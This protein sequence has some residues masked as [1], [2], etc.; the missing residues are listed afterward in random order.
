M[1]GSLLNKK[2]ENERDQLD[3]VPFL[4]VYHELMLDHCGPPSSFESPSR[5]S[6]ISA[7]IRA[8]PYACEGANIK[9]EE[10]MQFVLRVHSRAH[11]A[12]LDSLAGSLASERSKW[13]CSTCSFV[14]EPT[15][16]LCDMCK[17]RQPKNKWLYFEQ[18]DGDTTY[19]NSATRTA[20]LKAVKCACKLALMLVQ[21]ET[22][23]GFAVV[24]PPGHHAG[25]ERVEGFCVLNS[26]AI[27]AE[28]ALAAG[29]KRIFIFDWDV[30]HGNGIQ[31]HFY[32]RADVFYASIHAEGIYP[33][34][35]NEEDV[36]DGEGVG[37]TLNVPLS[38]GTDT[39]QYVHAFTRAILPAMEGYAPDL[40]IIAAGF[41]ALSSDPMH[42]FDVNQSAY[43]TMLS[44][45]SAA[46]PTTPVGLI[47]EGGYDSRSIASAIDHCAQVLFDMKS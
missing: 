24:R 46:L 21:G 42:I 4:Y 29:A 12:Y 1:K 38:K 13:G 15:S 19:Y 40:V 5:F 6:Q 14:N 11:L 20:S 8:S 31:D 43:S 2:A 10:V 45:I 34:T 23:S 7:L 26:T 9:D 18:L 47:L 25:R 3:L 27:A 39:K 16:S 22:K 44:S 28:A 30:H 41:D 35:G 37:F 32:K 17:E 36:G 33:H